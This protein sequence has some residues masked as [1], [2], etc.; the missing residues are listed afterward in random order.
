V[1]AAPPLEALAA[2]SYEAA[3]SLLAA[4]GA[5]KLSRQSWALVPKILEA[6]EIAAADDRI[7]EVHPEVSFSHMAGGHISWSKKSWNGLM[8]RRSLL[9]AEGITV[10]DQVPALANVG[11]DDVVDACAA[12]WSAQRIASGKGRSLPDP[13]EAH[14]GRLVAIWY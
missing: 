4:R 2:E 13:P 7:I 3:N 8:L 11:A 9:A 1:F 5:P 14:N 6:A 12:A 10:P